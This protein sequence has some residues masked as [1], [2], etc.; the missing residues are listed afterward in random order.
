MTGRKAQFS[1]HQRIRPRALVAGDTIGICTPSFPAHVHFRDKYLHGISV[2]RGLGFNVIEG[3]L[4]AQHIADGYRSG[5]PLARAQ[6][7]MD[8]FTNP[9]VSGIVTTI[10]GS[11]SSSLIPHLDFELIRRNP[12][13]F[14]GYSDVTS[15]HLALLA[16]AGLCTFYGPAVVPSFGEWP[17]LPTLTRESFLDA[18]TSVS[19]ARR[20]LVSAKT[21]ANEMID[22]TSPG[23]NTRARAQIPTS[24]P[25]VIRSG[26]VEAPCIV[27]NL[28]TLVSS[29]GTP[30]FPNVEGR[31]LVVE[32]M[33]A[34]LSNQERNFRHLER[35]GVFEAIAAL[36]VGKPEKYSAEGACFNYADLVA[37][38]VP[39]RAGQPLVMDF[40]CGHTAP[41][42][43]IA[44]M[45]T[46]RLEAEPGQP[47][48]VFVCESMVAP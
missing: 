24:G 42:H 33:D 11:C 18:T 41:M 36:V 39:E 4:T 28:N 2:L 3:T 43:T 7:L 47:A 25:C 9:L 23:W 35:L 1:D 37:E 29:A 17:T 26:F 14:C 22:A 34:L 10:G 5:S 38:I 48:R 20:E 27:A 16:H 40:D 6:E 30:Y 15:L 31:I 21:F 46:L 44:Q 32:E 8:L 19:S 45:T 13:V 12:K